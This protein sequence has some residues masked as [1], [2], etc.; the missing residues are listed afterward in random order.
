MDLRAL[1]P[2]CFFCAACSFWGV[3]W[4]CGG[5][6]ECGHSQQGASASTRAGSAS[7]KLKDA[8]QGSS[9][10]VDL[11]IPITLRELMDTIQRSGESPAEAN[12]ILRETIGKASPE[13]LESMLAAELEVCGFGFNL[14]SSSLG[15]DF[16]F[17][18]LAEIA[19]DRAA[20]LCLQWLPLAERI[21]V[22]LVPW[23]RRDPDAFLSWYNRLPL[24]AQKVTAARCRN[25]HALDVIATIPAHAV[26][27]EFA[28]SAPGGHFLSSGPL[29]P[30]TR[31]PFP[32]ALSGA[33]RAV[34]SSMREQAE[35]DPVGA[36]AALESLSNSADYPA[37]VYGFVSAVAFENPSLA[38][39][40][41][42][43]IRAESA[44]VR[45]A[46][47]EIVARSWVR[48]EPDEA[49]IWAERAMLTDD[50]YFALT[51]RDRPR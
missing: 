14:F 49:R 8:L 3:R 1:F 23:S 44:T 18:R 22:A 28:K 10:R 16:A 26:V 15:F 30:P 50:E 12:R 38:A 36:A 2:L 7:S 24:D 51:G 34:F 4:L 32:D 9:R 19:P 39:E 42:L 43:S 17:R 25:T 33:S 45:L 31:N 11:E 6:L 27:V 40:W 21:E 35:K 29:L 5:S 47:L 13:Q 48:M 46:A 41:A 37:A 20:S